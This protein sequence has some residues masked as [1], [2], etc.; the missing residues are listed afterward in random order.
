MAPL[1][2]AVRLHDIFIRRT[3]MTPQPDGIVSARWASTLSL[4]ILSQKSCQGKCAVKLSSFSHPPVSPLHHTIPAFSVTSILGHAIL[5]SP[6]PL[7]F[8]FMFLLLTLIIAVLHLQH[9]LTFC[10]YRAALLR[11][12]SHFQSSADAPDVYLPGRAGL[13]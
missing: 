12:Y 1:G 9:N 7:S 8:F 3:T 2:P 4:A 6:K 10:A 5:C 13:S 11:D